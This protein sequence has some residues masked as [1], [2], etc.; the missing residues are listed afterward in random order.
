MNV[1]LPVA[2]FSVSL[3][4]SHMLSVLPCIKAFLH[5]SILLVYNDVIRL[6]HGPGLHVL[7]V[8]SCSSRHSRARLTSSSLAAA[9]MS[10]ISISESTTLPR[11]P[12]SCV[13]TQTLSSTLR[14]PRYDFICILCAF[15]SSTSVLLSRSS[16]LSCDFGSADV[17][18]CFSLTS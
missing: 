2:L 17:N 3:G 6:Q 5:E 14:N 7:C 13:A 8:R 9:S 10:S 18:T 16:H 4:F 12:W 15:L 1:L 11:P